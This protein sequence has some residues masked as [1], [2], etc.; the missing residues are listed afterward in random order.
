MPC[1]Y[2]QWLQPRHV[3]C[4]EETHKH[5]DHAQEDDNRRGDV[6]EWVHQ[7]GRV[8]E[9]HLLFCLLLFLVVSPT[10][11]LGHLT[12]RLLHELLHVH[13]GGFGHRLHLGLA[14]GS[15]SFGCICPG[16]RVGFSLLLRLCLLAHHL[17]DAHK[18]LHKVL[19]L[20][21]ATLELHPNGCQGVQH[22][23]HI[24]IRHGIVEASHSEALRLCH[25]VEHPPIQ[26]DR[27]HTRP[28]LAV[29]HADVAG[30]G[31]TVEQASLEDKH[32]T[33]FN[34]LFT[35]R[36]HISSALLHKLLVQERREWRHV[37]EAHDEHSLCA[38]LLVH[39]RYNHTSVL[40][41]CRGLERC[42]CLL[43]EIQL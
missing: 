22:A 9:H 12:P 36:P 30:V 18:V 10:E 31:I 40:E 15:C 2:G 33:R 14:F 43:S 7:V 4:D 24:N 3:H 27:M 42:M 16:L 5:H 13:P 38:E 25:V 34:K 17:D 20:H 11:S 39:G 35:D 1:Q 23:W 8:L 32:A 37:Q 19:A 6:L 41:G 21:H 29:D 26:Q 28:V